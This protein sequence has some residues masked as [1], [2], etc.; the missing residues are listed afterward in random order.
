MYLLGSFPELTTEYYCSGSLNNLTG[1][2]LPADDKYETLDI[3]GRV[4]LH[5]TPSL[6]K[7]HA[8]IK[9]RY[10]HTLNEASLNET[11][12]VFTPSPT[13]ALGVLWWPPICCEG[14]VM[15][16]RALLSSDHMEPG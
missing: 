13:G 1:A 15:V 12:P 10:T 14:A 4:L 5:V 7:T 9:N 8:H 2:S 11:H 3:L 6:P 16:Q